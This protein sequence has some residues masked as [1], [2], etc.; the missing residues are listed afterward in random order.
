MS[1]VSVWIEGT[2]GRRWPVSFTCS[3][4]RSTSNDV[5]IDDGLVSRRHALIHKQDDAEYWIIDLGSGN[6]TY[7][8]GRRV[9]LATRLTNG[10]R[11]TFG[12]LNYTFRSGVSS[13]VRPGP[14]SPVSVQTI[15]QIK[16]AECWLLVAD[17][18]GSTALAQRLPATELA[19]LV[20]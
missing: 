9:A 5:V 4:G 3:I 17:I 20:G 14:S 10:D 13:G 16:T 7:L 19:V 12:P 2:D 18:K 15:I 6:G 11:L 8:N 1:E